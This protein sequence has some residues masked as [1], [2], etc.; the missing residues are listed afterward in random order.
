MQM[1]GLKQRVFAIHGQSPGYEYDE[2]YK[3]L[4]LTQQTSRVDTQ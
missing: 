4:R 3:Y 1:L 2:P